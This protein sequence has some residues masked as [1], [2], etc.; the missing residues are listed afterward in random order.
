MKSVV[1]DLGNTNKKIALFDDMSLI[2][3]EQY[4]GFDQE[5]LTGFISRNPDAS[6][7]ILSSVVSYPSGIRKFLSEKFFF[8][9]MNELTPLPVTL[10]YQ[11]RNSLGSDRIAAAVAGSA[12]FPGHEVLVINMGTCITFDFINKEKEY[13]G[14]S[15]SPGVEMRFRALHTFTGKLPLISSGDYHDS[16]LTGDSTDGSIRS[17]VLNGTL[18]EIEGVAMRYLQ[19]WPDLKIILSGGDHKY[20]VKWLKI[21]IFAHPNI[22]LSGLQQILSFNVYKA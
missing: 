16:E 10:R 22:V 18:A 4:P 2:S 1:I 12:R 17:G 20:F 11:T 15:I 14:G 21:S 19:R 8:L 5:I 3:V 13:L 9:E 6:H 7:C